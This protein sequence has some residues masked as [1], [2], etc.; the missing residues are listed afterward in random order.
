MSVINRMLRDLEAR[1]PSNSAPANAA[2]DAVHATPATA[3]RRRLWLLLLAGGAAISVAGFGDWPKAFSMSSR[4]PTP[5]AMLDITVAA[6]TPAP[7]PPAAPLQSAPQNA[8]PGGAT[9]A[10]AVAPAPT[11]TARA[12]RE[13]RTAE[14]FAKV[15][16][17]T[18]RR[19]PQSVP[20]PISVN[21]SPGAALA[22]PSA[23]GN[24]D[25]RMLL[26]PAA[27]RAQSLFRQG[28]ELAGTG[29]ARAA[30]DKLQ[31]ALKLDAGLLSA[32]HGAATLWLELG[33]PA[34]AETLALQGLEL[35]PQEPRLIYL[36]ARI[37]ADRGD[38]AG[39]IARLDSSRALDADGFGLRA[40]LLSQQG[41][42]QRALADYEQAVRQQPG[43]SLWWLGL[44]VALEA[45]GHAPQA[46]QAYTRAQTIGI[47]RHD[48]NLF[49][50]QKLASL[51]GAR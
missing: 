46:R 40:G 4:S 37:L 23:P 5:A 22:E 29:H 3:P 38:A 2:S 48:L 39:A 34:Q 27:Q 16:A 14:P 7:V 18:M 12:E 15:A 20:S 21:S 19:A 51:E 49:V 17:A 26:L 6:E 32:R 30:L 43:N 50:D 24:V 11:L 47:A 10:A 1:R 45:A 31:E 44:G 28:L 9:G 36:L 42:F 41:N 8:P 33:Q 35:A 13:T 25:K